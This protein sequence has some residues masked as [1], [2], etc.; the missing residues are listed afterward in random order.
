MYLMGYTQYLIFSLIV[1][2]LVL[3]RT[4]SLLMQPGALRNAVIWLALLTGL[5]WGYTVFHKEGQSLTPAPAIQ[6]T[7]PAQEPATSDGPVSNL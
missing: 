1:L 4:R 5:V 7:A 2:V 6:E 3:P